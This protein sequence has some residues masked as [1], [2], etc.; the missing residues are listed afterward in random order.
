MERKA[1][2]KFWKLCM[3][4]FDDILRLRN[5]GYNNILLDEIS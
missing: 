5:L 2:W 3:L 4:F 1:D